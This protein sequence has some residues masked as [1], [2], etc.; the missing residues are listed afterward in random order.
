M[1]NEVP[2]PIAQLVLR[3]PDLMRGLFRRLVGRDLPSGKE[4]EQ[5]VLGAVF[6]YA[7]RTGDPTKVSLILSLI[8]RLRQAGY[9]VDTEFVK[10]AA[11]VV[12]GRQQIINPQRRDPLETGGGGGG[13]YETGGVAKAES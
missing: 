9:S 8:Q 10:A 5:A 3:F 11:G 13:S 7:F 4:D 1:L 2:E 6:F 12:G